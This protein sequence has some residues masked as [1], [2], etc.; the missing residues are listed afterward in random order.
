MPKPL[1]KL[2]RRDLTGG[3]T[4]WNPVLIP[5]RRGRSQRDLFRADL[6]RGL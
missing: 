2:R 4:E 3:H 5:N 6:Y 1:I